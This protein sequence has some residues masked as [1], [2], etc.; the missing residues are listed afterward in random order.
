[1]TGCGCGSSAVSSPGPGFQ[2]STRPSLLP[3]A[4]LRPSGLNA[5]ALTQSVAP[6]RAPSGA[7]RAGVIT[8]H[9]QTLASWLPAASSARP[10]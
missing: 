9:N 5:T 8:F 4:R 1:M 7:G 3:A 6:V 2:T 10:G